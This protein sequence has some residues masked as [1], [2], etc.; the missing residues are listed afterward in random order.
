MVF[1]TPVTGTCPHDP[2]TVAEA[3]YPGFFFCLTIFLLTGRFVKY[4]RGHLMIHEWAGFPTFVLDPKGPHRIGVSIS[5]DDF[6]MFL[7]KY[8]LPTMYI[9]FYYFYF[10]HKKIGHLIFLKFENLKEKEKSK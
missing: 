5:D 3:V 8:L 2:L 1:F 9:Y 7:T 4:A 6:L 10:N